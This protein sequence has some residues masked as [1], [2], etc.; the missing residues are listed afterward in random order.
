MLL[1]EN[2]NI[3]KIWDFKV[4]ETPNIK[5]SIPEGIYT[6]RNTGKKKNFTVAMAGTFLGTEITTMSDRVV[7][8][9]DESR[10]I[11]MANALNKNI[12]LP[13]YASVKGID[14]HI[15]ITVN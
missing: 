4:S 15:S 13:V 12:C 3:K 9:I 1:S 2:K 6:V 8:A 5:I 7:M 11:C 14:S 10:K